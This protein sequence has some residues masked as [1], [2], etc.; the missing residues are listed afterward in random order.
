MRCRSI[1]RL[2]RRRLFFF[3][4]FFFFTSHHFSRRCDVS[5]P[6]KRW[7]RRMT[8]IRRTLYQATVRLL[9]FFSVLSSL[10]CEYTPFLSS[11]ACDISPSCNNFDSKEAS[12]VYA[13]PA[14]PPDVLLSPL[15]GPSSCSPPSSPTFVCESQS[16]IPWTT[17]SCIDRIMK[18]SCMHTS[19]HRRRIR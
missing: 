19:V 18:R 8:G 13:P 3:F 6:R 12:M 15:P 14:G 9:N 2:I 4:F 10:L 5:Y 1:L 16:G 17:V 11:Q 7:Q